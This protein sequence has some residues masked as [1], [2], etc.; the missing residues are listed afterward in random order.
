MLAMPL[1]RGFEWSSARAFE[2]LRVTLARTVRKSDDTLETLASESSSGAAVVAQSHPLTSMIDGL[3]A[4]DD[5]RLERVSVTLSPL[6][7]E[8]WVVETQS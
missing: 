6:C 1:A 7:L 2:N 8:F 4:G 5:R 3:D